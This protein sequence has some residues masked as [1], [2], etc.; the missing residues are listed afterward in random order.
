MSA[1]RDV[2]TAR[3]SATTTPCPP[4]PQTLDPGQVRRAAQKNDAGV[5]HLSSEA[6]EETPTTDSPPRSTPDAVGP[7]R[8]ATQTGSAD[9]YLSL[10]A[11]AEVYEDIQRVRIAVFNRIDRAPIDSE[12]LS[13]ALGGIA[14]FDKGGK[15]NGGSEHRIA[16]LLHRTFRKVVEPEIRAWAKDT[17]GVG[18]HMLARLLG[19]IGHPVHTTV[20]DWEGDGEER[21]LFVKGQMERRVSDLWSYCGHGDPNRR[22]RKGMSAKETALLGSPRAKMIVHLMAESCL[23]A[24]ARSPYGPVY[25]FARAKYEARD[26]WTPMHQHNAA[27]RLV[28]KEIL[29]DL[30][31]AAR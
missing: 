24:K 20:H 8:V 14:T 28:G 15:V 1:A 25:D 4:S 7:R 19:V 26:G 12:I 16:L 10:R 2:G 29:R 5:D 23:K 17:I 22:R 31:T 18:E 30:W 6:I 3:G 21:V 11:I 27:L 9:G 13:A